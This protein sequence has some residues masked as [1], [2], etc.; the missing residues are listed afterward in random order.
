MIRK[1]LLAKYPHQREENSS[2]PS[3][4]LS[5]QSSQC[6]TRLSL[7]RMKQDSSLFLQDETSSDTTNDI[8]SPKDIKLSNLRL[9]DMIDRGCFSSVHD[10]QYDIKG[11]SAISNVESSSVQS[12][13]DDFVIKRAR[14]S[15]AWDARIESIVSLAKEAQFLAQLSHEHIINME[16]TIGDPGN[17][18]YYLILERMT[19]TLSKEMKR[20]RKEQNFGY[21]QSKKS[22]QEALLHRLD[23]GRQICIAMK[24]LHENMVVFR[25][26]KPDNVGF[27]KNHGKVKLFDFGLAKELKVRDQVS[28]N[29]YKNTQYVGTR[30]YMAPEV[31]N[32]DTYGLAV[33]V[34]SFGI[35]LWELFTLK[36]AFD[37][38]TIFQ[39][40]D[41]AYNRNGRPR[42]L[43]G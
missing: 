29:N 10:I 19:S 2:N 34:Y 33:D 28:E 8:S 1:V 23:V 32:S 31:F 11:N 6:R 42:I 18:D 13:R 39:H 22:K 16:G 41:F 38:L 36:I 7:K 14:S 17:D 3:R 15:L 37:G 9:G 25:D 24:Y 30:R 40:S 5:K 43:F 12:S 26:L 4:R 35:L 20:W 21:N 27:D